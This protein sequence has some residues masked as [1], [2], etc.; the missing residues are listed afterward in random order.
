M[1]YGGRK[2]QRGMK[3]PTFH[4]ECREVTI[5]CALRP[6][7]PIETT[8]CVQAQTRYNDFLSTLTPEQRCKRGD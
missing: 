8:V 7:T 6:L 4:K 1:R 5:D 2:I 3:N